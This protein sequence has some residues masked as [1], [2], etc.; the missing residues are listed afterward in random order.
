MAFPYDLQKFYGVGNWV[1]VVATV[2]K[3]GFRASLR[4]KG[5]FLKRP[6][7][8]IPRRIRR[9]LR[10]AVGET[11]SVTVTLDSEQRG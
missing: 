2:D 7:L 1:P 8:R 10:K 3:R 11:V 4:R 5:W 6:Y 9:R